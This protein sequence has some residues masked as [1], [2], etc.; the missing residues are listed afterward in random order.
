MEN[1][2]D[3]IKVID[4]YYTDAKILVEMA[5][6]IVRLVEERRT[7]IEGVRHKAITAWVR[8]LRKDDDITSAD[9][10]EIVCE[11][12]RQ[13]HKAGGQRASALADILAKLGSP[14]LDF[15]MQYLAAKHPEVLDEIFDGGGGP[16]Q[17][18]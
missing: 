16:P 15:A 3:L 5:T 2:K 7:E 14:V 11:W 1:L 18:G 4:G 13:T 12:I 9:T 6:G 17:E 8:D 10:A